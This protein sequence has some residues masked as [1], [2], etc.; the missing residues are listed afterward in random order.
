[1]QLRQELHSLKMKSGEP[2]TMY[3]GRAKDLFRDLTATGFELKPDELAW[4]ML[5]G[6][7]SSFNTLR[8]ILE[9]LEG[10]L[11]SVDAILPKLLVHEQ[12]FK[13][14]KDEGGGGSDAAVAYAA[15]RKGGK[16]KSHG[17]DESRGKGPKCYNCGEFGHIARKC[18]KPD[19]R[20]LK[21]EQKKGGKPSKGVAFSVI[22]GV[23]ADEWLVD[24]GSSQHLTGDK[25]LFEMLEMFGGSGREFTFGDQGTLWAEGSG[26]VELQCA[27][28]TEESLVTLQNVMYVPGVAANLISVSKATEVATV[29]FKENSCEL[30]VDGEVVLVARKVKGIYIV[31]RAENAR[32]PKMVHEGA[33]S[34][35]MRREG[36]APGEDACFL[37]R[38]PETA[39]LW[40]QR[41]GHAGYE[42]LAKM[43]Q[44]DLVEG[45]GVKPS[46]LRALKTSV[47]EPCIIGKQTR[48][49]FPKSESVSTKPLELVHMDVC[50]PMP[51][52]SIGGSRYFATFLDDYSKLSIVVP[53][54]QKSEVAKVTEW[55]INRLELQSGK[56]LKSVR[57]DRGKEYVNKALENVSGGKGTVHEKTAPY[58]AE[59]N[60]SAERLNR[61]LEEK[62]RAML[63]D[64][65]LL[66]DLWAEAVVTANYTRNRTPVSAHGM[67]PWEAFFGKKPKLGHMRVFGAR[68]FA[69]VPKERRRKLDPVSERG[70][71]VGYEPDS[72]AYRVLRE[73]DGKLIIRRDVIFDEGANG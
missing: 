29:L 25:S 7:P 47:C 27:T 32:S 40:H 10:A 57:T 12:G 33:F 51:V 42:N 48:Q 6:L 21:P 39:E 11:S 58:T 67:T 63:D 28:P 50:R 3:V 53:M 31:D 20:E 54:K 73:S 62:V 64:S 71:F 26:S 59:Q 60:G 45:V 36:A 70:V 23:A 44:D 65:R 8:T 72:K 43:V 2:V 55:T 46:A 52:P 22:E 38:K 18:S 1:M 24:S 35:M 34:E 14:P 13:L 30:E 17:K 4:S 19:R 49:P 15:Q 5:A 37:V 66:K 69:H 61:Q 68:A 16:E 56:K 41:M 9:T